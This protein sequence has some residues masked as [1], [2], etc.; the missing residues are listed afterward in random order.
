M[1]NKICVITGSNSCIG[2]ATAIDL[3][4]KGYEIK[5]LSGSK[6]IVLK[7]VELSS[8]GSIK[9]TAEEIKAEYSKLD[10]L[11][12][13]AGVFKKV[14]GKSTDGVPPS[15]SRRIFGFHQSYTRWRPSGSK[16]GVTSSTGKAIRTL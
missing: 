16:S 11:I 7:F 13:N 9:K 15:P 1:E 10:V 4:K 2:K 12:N 5:Q 14:E 8:L 3:A 6:K